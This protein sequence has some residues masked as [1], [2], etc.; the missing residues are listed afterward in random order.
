MVGQRSSFRLFQ[1]ATRNHPD[2]QAEVWGAGTQHPKGTYTLGLPCHPSPAWHGGSRGATGR[3][4]SLAGSGGSSNNDYGGGRYCRGSGG[5]G[6][7]GWGRCP[8]C[9][10]PTVCTRQAE[11]Q[12]RGQLPASPAAWP[13]RSSGRSPATSPTS[14]RSSASA[15]SVSVPPSPQAP[16]YLSPEPCCHFPARRQEGVSGIQWLRPGRAAPA[17]GH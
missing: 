11:W 13:W 5:I 10:A 2:S 4:V 9:T 7:D 14:R 17:M 15:S 6:W 16:T 8:P 3:L 1:E 12:R